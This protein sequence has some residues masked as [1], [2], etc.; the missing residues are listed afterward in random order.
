MS[1]AAGPDIVENG[2]VLALD[3]GNP[4]GFDNDE[5]LFT[6]NATDFNYSFDNQ[7]IPTANDVAPDG[8]TVLCKHDLTGAT[9]PFLNVNVDTSLS[10][11][12]YT[13]S[14]WL[15]GTTSYSA[16]F[17]FVGET[18]YEIYAN[19][20]NITTA[21]QRFTLIFTLINTQTL[22]RL[23]V[24]FGSQGEGKVISVWGAQLERGSVAT[25]YTTRLSGTAKNRGTVLIDLSGKGNNGT[26]VGGTG[27][28]PDNGGSLVFDGVDDT[29]TVPSS[30]SLGNDKVNTAPIISLDFWA[31]V[32]RKSGGGQQFQQLAGFRNDDGIFGFYVLLIDNSGE[33]VL[34]ETRFRNSAGTSFDIFVD[35]IP[36]FN[37]WTHIGFVANVNRTDLYINANLVGSR[38]DVS[39]SF[40]ASSGNFEIGGFGQ[41]FPTLGN[42]SSVKVYNRALS[43]AEVSQNFNATRSRYSV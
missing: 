25:D 30:A 29:V 40:G 20:A 10:P 41:V 5:N 31:N 43:A 16:S 3:A 9:S 17:S 22:S 13:M 8:T 23:Q 15:K 24:F 18:T 7:I 14:M 39:G 4:K 1:C 6:D 2:L 34:T 33:T 19:I 28:N 26:L 37:K 21:W 32:T 36:Y 35:Y 11:G 42:I 27:Y 12:S 38:T